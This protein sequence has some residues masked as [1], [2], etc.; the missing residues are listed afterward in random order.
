MGQSI[1]QDE[2][3]LDVEKWTSQVPTL[4]GH[5]AQDEDTFEILSIAVPEMLP[6]N[7]VG[8]VINGRS[9]AQARKV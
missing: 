4:V 9:R 7:Q 6:F 2:T 5:G 3:L 8:L 1:A